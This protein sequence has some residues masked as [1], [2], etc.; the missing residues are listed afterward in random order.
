MI[1][2]DDA[3]GDAIFVGLEPF[4][5]GFLYIPKERKLYI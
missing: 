3:A 5:V 4:G 2:D 1:Y